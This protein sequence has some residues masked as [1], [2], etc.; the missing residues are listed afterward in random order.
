MNIFSTLNLVFE[1]DISFDYRQRLAHYFDSLARFNSIQIFF[2]GSSIR[3][4]D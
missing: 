1:I 3:F 2:E 4:F